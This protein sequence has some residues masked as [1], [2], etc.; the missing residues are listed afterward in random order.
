MAMGRIYARWIYNGKKTLA[1]VPEKYKEATIKGY[2]DLFGLKL[3]ETP[4]EE[5]TEEPADKK[6][7]K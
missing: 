7:A 3:E 2:W 4:A 6:K 5:Q 1:D